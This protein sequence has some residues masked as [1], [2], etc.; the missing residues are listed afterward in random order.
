MPATPR[1]KVLLL[2]ADVAAGGDLLAAAAALGADAYVAT[3]ADLYARYRPELTG[4]IAGT[5]FTDFADPEA[6][7]ADLTAFG[8]RTGIDGIVPCW[9]FLTPLAAHL[10]A[11]LGLPGH[12][13]G[14]APAGRNKRLM[15]KAFAA[16]GV[17]APRT[18]SAPDPDTL[19]RR[20]DAAGLG[21][22]LVVK[23]A[24][25]AASIGVSVVTAPGELPAAA[26]RARTGPRKLPHGIPLDTA[27][28]AQE[29]V[30][31][32]EFSV[33]TVL[34]DGAVH[35]LA[36]T[37]K[38][39]TGGA[40]RAELGHTV[41]AALPPDTRA[42]VYGAATAAVTALGLRNG[43]A[44]TE[45]KLDPAGRPVVLEVGAR[46]PGDHIMRL[47]REALG[48]DM[49]RAHLQAVLGDRP[50][51]TPRR[52]AAAAIRFLTAPEAGT[53]RWV[54][55]LPR[56]PHIV[57]TALTK[58]PGDAV[59]GPDDNLSRIG[60]IMVRAASPAE[61]SAAADAALASVAVEL[62]TRW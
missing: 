61:A 34:T 42:A 33:E 41:P 56:G 49:A 52:D 47:V 53:L 55:L 38:F 18:V 48:I 43:L 6:A 19:A 25:E 7:L 36:V 37:E 44:H 12:L 17:P 39:T 26:R 23:P 13:P 3:R 5:A 54:G 2:E 59:G 14:T 46:P 1:R 20:A 31:G 24:E 58:L 8:R 28:L 15:A 27:V 57:E 51:V 9:E 62:A 21:Y 29:Y 4:R 22:P 11:A 40:R 16:H 50:D 35:H 10:A 45:L 60:H 32:P 30:A